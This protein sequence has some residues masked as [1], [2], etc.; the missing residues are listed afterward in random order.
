MS[1]KNI[2]VFSPHPDD[3]VFSCSG[4]MNDHIKKGDSVTIIY[5]TDGGLGWNER[6]KNLYFNRNLVELRE[7]ESIKGAAALGIAEK[8]LVFL[9]FPEKIY[10]HPDEKAPLITKIKENLS[11]LQPDLIYLAMT[12]YSNL[13]HVATYFYVFNTL[14]EQEYDGVIRVAVPLK[15]KFIKPL[16]DKAKFEPQFQKI[17]QHFPIKKLISIETKNQ[18]EDKLQSILAHDSQLGIFQKVIKNTKNYVETLIRFL[19]NLFKDNI[20]EFEERRRI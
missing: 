17:N 3:E 9:R 7:Q 18:F 5:L 11:L 1:N 19:K 12:N 14:L 15:H 13:D 6:A 2:I 16:K 20:E 10:N 8:N 4:A